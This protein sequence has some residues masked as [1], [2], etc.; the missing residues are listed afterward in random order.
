VLHLTYFFIADAKVQRWFGFTNYLY[1][2]LGRSFDNQKA[3]NVSTA[4]QFT[5]VPQIGYTE[6]L[7]K[8]SPAL[9]GVFFDLIAN[10]SLHTSG[11][12][13]LLVVNPPTAPVPGVVTYDTLTQ[14]PSYD[15]R[16]FLRYEPK[17]FLFVAVVS[18]NRGVAS[19]SPWA[20]DLLR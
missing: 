4:S 6:G 7:E 17:P 1:L 13:P 2:P 18:K 10:A 9:H 3:V 14:R 15:V 12:I 20:A 19:R 8:L 16:A 11:V 5:D